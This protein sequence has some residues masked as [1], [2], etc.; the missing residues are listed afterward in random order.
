M[1]GRAEPALAARQRQRSTRMAS[2]F[3]NETLEKDD[4]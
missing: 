1:T 3:D 2:L 4:E